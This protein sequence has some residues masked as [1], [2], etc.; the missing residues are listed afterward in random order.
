MSNPD[1]DQEQKGRQRMN[2]TWMLE[3]PSDEMA[4][5]SSFLYR[6]YSLYSCF[7]VLL[8]FFSHWNVI[9]LSWVKGYIHFPNV[10]IVAVLF[11]SICLMS[12]VSEDELLTQK[13]EKTIYRIVNDNR[14][15]SLWWQR[16]TRTCHTRWSTSLLLVKDVEHSWVS[17]SLLPIPGLLGFPFGLWT[18]WW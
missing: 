10:I 14:S 6:D 17:S 4:T 3:M 8:L 7:T 15:R 13:D 9:S 12:S 1:D 16:K 5:K 2:Y 11:H 18:P